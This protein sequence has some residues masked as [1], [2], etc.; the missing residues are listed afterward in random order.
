MLIKTL[1]CLFLWGSNLS[2]IHLRNFAQILF[3]FDSNKN[4]FLSVKCGTT[5]V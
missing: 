1:L 5:A 2:D 4:Y 3:F